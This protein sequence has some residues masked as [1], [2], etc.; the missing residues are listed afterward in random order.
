MDRSK[1]ASSPERTE[2]CQRDR[3]EV[4]NS[5]RTL[6]ELWKNSGSGRQSSTGDRPEV[7][8]KGVR[9]TLNSET[10]SNRTRVHAGY[11]RVCTGLYTGRLCKVYKRIGN[12]YYASSFEAANCANGRTAEVAWSVSA[13]CEEEQRK[14]GPKLC[15]YHWHWAHMRA[16]SSLSEH[17][18]TLR[19]DYSK[20]ASLPR[21]HYGRR[22]YGHVA[23]WSSSRLC[24]ALCAPVAAQGRKAILELR[25]FSLSFSLS[26]SLSLS[27]SL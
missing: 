7:P 11:A 14:S 19:L 24:A 4:A 20:K 2:E 9:R 23:R 6:K 22:A 13:F 25:N 3:G 21:K 16:L 26:L 27:C 12:A 8:A 5:G 1:A 18:F 10:E 15:H 17:V